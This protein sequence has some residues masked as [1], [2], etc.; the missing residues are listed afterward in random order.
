MQRTTA[1][2]AAPAL[3]W[4]L[5]TA[6]LSQRLNPGAAPTVKSFD[7]AAH[8]NS[9]HSTRHNSSLFASLFIQN[10]SVVVAF[11]LG[12]LSDLCDQT[13]PLR[14]EV[15]ITVTETGSDDKTLDK[16]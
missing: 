11:S 8:I 4:K 15:I 5:P 3:S 10:V 16:I 1:Q 2:S 6:W 7:K 12:L 14:V 13:T 9:K